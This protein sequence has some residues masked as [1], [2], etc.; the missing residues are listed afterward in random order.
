MIFVDISQDAGKQPKLEATYNS[1]N[2]THVYI[3]KEAMNNTL[4]YYRAR[5]ACG[6]Y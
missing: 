1:N 6:G 4:Y 5:A 3:T 2:P